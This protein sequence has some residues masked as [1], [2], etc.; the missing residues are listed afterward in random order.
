MEGEW[1]VD[2]RGV[3]MGL[4]ITKMLVETFEGQ[5][6]LDSELGHG[7][8]FGFTFKLSEL[9]QNSDG[10]ELNSTSY[11]SKHRIVVNRPLNDHPQLQQ[12]Q[13]YP[14]QPSLLSF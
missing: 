2:T 1:G 10:R 8:T 5:V 12:M 7:S 3:G 6:S 13:N 9:E 14:L 4:H 11:W